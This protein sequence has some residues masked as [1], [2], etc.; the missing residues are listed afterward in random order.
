MALLDAIA[1]CAAQLSRAPSDPDFA[2]EIQNSY[3]LS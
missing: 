3:I 1:N 2:G